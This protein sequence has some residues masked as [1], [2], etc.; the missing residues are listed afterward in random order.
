MNNLPKKKEK[1]T[2]PTPS[3]N[4]KK[5]EDNKKNKKKQSTK[6]KFK[7]VSVNPDNKA[8]NLNENGN[9]QEGKNLQK[10]ITI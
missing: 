5:P 3:N 9:P 1:E 8:P 7:R 6:K 4:I 2:L 10:M